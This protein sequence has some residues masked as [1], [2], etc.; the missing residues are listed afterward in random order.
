MV[1]ILLHINRFAW[2]FLKKRKKEKK[3]RCCGR[4]FRRRIFNL[5]LHEESPSVR[6]SSPHQVEKA[7]QILTVGLPDPWSQFSLR[8]LFRA[9]LLPY[10]SL[11]SWWFPAP[12][13]D[14]CKRHGTFIRRHCPRTANNP[15]GRKHRRVYTR[16]ESAAG[17]EAQRRK[18]EKGREKKKWLKE[19]LL[20][21]ASRRAISWQLV[22][23]SRRP[24]P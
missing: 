1:P 14:P 3:R 22:R 11:R 6:Q 5:F 20:R 7:T 18:K 19:I 12:S 4:K 23:P 16:H 15:H 13:R 8:R 10:T 17:Q 21:S 9:S 24:G 2:N